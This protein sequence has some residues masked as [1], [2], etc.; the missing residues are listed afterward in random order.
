MLKSEPTLSS[1]PVTITAR[2][3]G[4]TEYIEVMP[5]TSNVYQLKFRL[6]P[7]VGAGPMRIVLTQAGPNNATPTITLDDVRMLSHYATGDTLAC[8]IIVLPPVEPVVIVRRNDDPADA[9]ADMDDVMSE[10]SD[11]ETD[12][13]TSSSGD[14]LLLGYHDME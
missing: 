3:L 12:S 1:M 11:D 8:T 13:S 9:D 6:C 5:P 10:A 2:T 4:G 14:T 7:L